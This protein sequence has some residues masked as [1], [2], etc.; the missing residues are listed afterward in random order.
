[1]KTRSDQQAQMAYGAS[2]PSTHWSVI[3]QAGQAGSPQAQQALDTLCRSYWYPVYAFLRRRGHPCHE[4]QDL[5][6]GFF[7]HLLRQDSF[8]AVERVEGIKF[9]S[10]LLGTLRNFITSEWRKTQAEIRGIRGLGD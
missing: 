7:A 5:T 2:M 9:R 6:Q 1:M 10:W 3:F 8:T 4:A